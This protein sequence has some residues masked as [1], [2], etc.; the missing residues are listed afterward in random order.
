MILAEPDDAFR[1][2]LT[3]TTRPPQ[4]ANP[5][6]KERY[7]VVVLGGGPA[8]LV[9]AAGAAGLGAKVALVERYRLGGD[10]LH[11]GCVPSKAILRCARAVADV[12]RAKEFGV[13]ASEPQVDFAKVMERM[14]RLRSSLAHADSAERFANVGVDVFFG[15]GSFLDRETIIVGGAK[16]RFMRAVIA[17]GARPADPGLPWLTP[18][19]YFTNETI[20]NLTTLPRRLLVLGAGP[21][22]CELAQAFA[23]FGSEVHLINRS[24]GVLA[25]DELEASDIVRRQ[26]ERDGLKLH[27][28]MRLLDG[29]RGFLRFEGNGQCA[30]LE[31]DALLVAVGRRANVESLNLGAAGIEVTDRGVKVDDRL[32]TTNP[33]VFAAG[34][35]CSRYQ[36]THAADAMARLVLRNALF[37][38]RRRMSSLV[39]PH[40]T[41]TD[42]EVA[43][44][45]LT[46][47]EAQERGI[48]LSTIRVPLGNVDRAV[49]DGETDGFAMV[50][51]RAGS[52][53]IVGA[54]IVAAH[55][56]DLIG[57]MVQAMT[58]GVG[59][60]SLAEL[61]RPYPTQAEVWK[62][63]A[64]AYQRSRLSSR[65]AWVLRRVIRLREHIS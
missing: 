38:G 29:G 49:L 42:P 2:E 1:R 52:D 32:R 26:L 9:C 50:H 48:A 10:C 13:I 57:E 63:I 21:I 4:W 23:R 44:V 56:G 46:A 30:R 58:R 3:E 47:R 33:R 8:G 15:D 59:L 54:T 27:L 64:D 17:T 43:S 19:D 14:R 25:R 60:G 5:T 6:P 55:A 24:P 7:H 37:F 45:G 39:I 31:G 51:M 20:F 34:D 18:D 61:V 65:T 11:F 41:Y 53:H 62:K 36:Y 40:C 12:R 16:L 22:G 28:G 35:V